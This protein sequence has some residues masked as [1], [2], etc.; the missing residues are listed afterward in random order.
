MPDGPVVITTRFERVVK[1]VEKELAIALQRAR[2]EADHAGIKGEKVE[3]AT[4]KVLRDR[5]PPNLR[6]GEGIVYDSFGDETGQTDIVV[7]NGEQPFTFPWGESGE[8]LIEGV[9]A[10]GE[11]KSKL[12][13]AELTDCIKKGTTYKHLRQCLGASDRILN[14]SPYMTETSVLPPFFVI[15]HEPGM[16]IK[17]LLQK[18]HDATPVPMPEG[19][20][21]PNDSPQPPLDAVCILGQGVAL[22]QRSGQGPAFRL[23]GAGKPFPGWI[24]MENDAP[25]AITLGWLHMAMPRILRAYSAVGL[26][27]MPPP[28]Q[29]KYMVNKARSAKGLE[30]V[31]G[32]LSPIQIPFT[33]IKPKPKKGVAKKAAKKTAAKKS[34][35]KK[36]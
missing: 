31:T 18:L 8:Y 14:R 20:D 35:A 9:S 16:T 4:R 34:A 22:N 13:P 26:Y 7:A 36:N 10:V 11:V 6:I 12:T 21:F 24:F 23:S 2:D 27:N 19:K 17:T 5:M 33:G 3:V 29:A 28:L 1:G 25:L 30:P 15:A 32:D